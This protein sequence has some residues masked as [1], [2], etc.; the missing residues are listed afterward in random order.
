M[1]ARSGEQALTIG[2]NGTW[3]RYRGNI[4]VDCIERVVPMTIDL[5]R[6][7]V[8][9]PMGQENEFRLY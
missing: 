3:K 6:A 2:G 4:P 1:D 5:A 7:V 8:A 9:L